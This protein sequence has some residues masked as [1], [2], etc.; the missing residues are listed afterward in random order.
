V[1]T[2][3]VKRAADVVGFLSPPILFKIMHANLDIDQP[4]VHSTPNFVDDFDKK[5]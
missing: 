1:V 3:A 5:P 4:A 2:G